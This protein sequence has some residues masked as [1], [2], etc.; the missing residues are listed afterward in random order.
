MEQ[1][2]CLFHRAITLKE[3]CSPLACGSRCKF[4]TYFT[5]NTRVHVTHTALRFILNTIRLKN[6]QFR[7]LFHRFQCIGKCAIIGFFGLDWINN[8]QGS[9]SWIILKKTIEFL[10][11]FTKSVLFNIIHIFS[12]PKIKFTDCF[13]NNFH[14]CCPINSNRQQFF[15]LFWKSRRP[16]YSTIS[17]SYPFL[18]KSLPTLVLEVFVLLNI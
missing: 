6:I 14:A 13:L 10:N 5:K 15:L 16:T 1:R 4:S 12:P 2:D 8:T 11:K 17:T 18:V 3:F 9:S 7:A